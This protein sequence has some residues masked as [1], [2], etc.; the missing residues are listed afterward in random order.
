[1][2]PL[3]N[4]FIYL[5]VMQ[6]KSKACHKNVIMRFQQGVGEWWGGVGGR[7]GKGVVKRPS[8]G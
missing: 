3:T 5:G 6:E 2:V 8:E 7:E 4:D 1:M